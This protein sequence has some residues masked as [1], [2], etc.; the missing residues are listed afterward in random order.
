MLTLKSH[1]WQHTFFSSLLKSTWSKDFQH[2]FQRKTSAM[3]SI[4]E[5]KKNNNP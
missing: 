3:Q 1:K 5:I 4:E 2:K